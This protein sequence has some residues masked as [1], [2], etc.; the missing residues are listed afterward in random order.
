M[1]DIVFWTLIRL[2][3]SIP[4]AWVLKDY[5]DYPIWWISIV[6]ILYG[7]V[8]Y[9]AIISYKK[10]EEKNK[11]LFESSLC[12][13]CRHFDKSAVLCIKYDKHP[14]LDYIPCEGMDWEPKTF[15]TE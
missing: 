15:E 5:L 6:I 3:I 7:F 12:S 1:G 10:F 9:P 14:T 4:L 2:A 8:V 13:S 11:N